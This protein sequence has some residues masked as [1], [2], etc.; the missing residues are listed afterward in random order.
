MNDESDVRRLYAHWTDL[1]CEDD[2]DVTPV[3]ISDLCGSTGSTGY[4]CVIDR[5]DHGT[6]HIAADGEHVVS[7]WKV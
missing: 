2:V 7:I 1:L 3:E 5:N 4:Q 6:R